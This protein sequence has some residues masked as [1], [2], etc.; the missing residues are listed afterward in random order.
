MKPIIET[1]NLSK[2]YPKIKGYR[3]LLLHSLKRQYITALDNVTLQ[4]DKG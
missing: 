1:I 4:I 3:D 2:H